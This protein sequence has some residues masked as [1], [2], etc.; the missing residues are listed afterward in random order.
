M[1]I[2]SEDKKNLTRKEVSPKN[3][4]NEKLKEMD[5]EEWVRKNPEMLHEK[6]LIIEQ[7]YSVD[8][9]NKLDLLAL[10]K[11]GR[12]VV[13]EIKRDKDDIAKD[14]VLGQA[15]RYVSCFSAA[16]QDEIV[17]IFR[18]HLKDND[19][20]KDAEEELRDFF[21]KG[22]DIRLNE[23]GQCI[24]LVAGDFPKEVTSSVMWLRDHKVDIRCIKV[25]LYQQDKDTLVDTEQIIPSYYAEREYRVKLKNKDRQNEVAMA[26]QRQYYEKCFEFWQKLLQ[27]GKALSDTQFKDAKPLRDRK[28]RCA[29]GVEGFDYELRVNTKSATISLDIDT[30]DKERNERILGALKKNRRK[31]AI[32][33]KFNGEEGEFDWEPYEKHRKSYVAYCRRNVDI[34]NKDDWKK[35]TE[36]FVKNT[37]KFIEAIQVHL[38]EVL[39]E[40]P[41]A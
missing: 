18:Q 28:I 33:S 7:Q 34:S 31:R 32:E 16:S 24:I 40:E 41:E 14:K 10:D 2:I 27:E 6:L 3:F 1:F 4:K 15:L 19:P 12:L 38:E 23:G 8:R 13:I 9:A 30:G 25:N 5:L 11:D 26:A 37:P 17:E 39:K 35:M 36:F 29:T 20:G 21:G 22:V